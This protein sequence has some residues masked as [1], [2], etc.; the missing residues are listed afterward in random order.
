MPSQADDR[1][2]WFPGKNNRFGTALLTD[3]TN[4]YGPRGYLADG[5]SG[6]PNTFSGVLCWYDFTGLGLSEGS[7]VT[8]VSDSSSAGAAAMTNSGAVT[9]KTGV[10]NGLGGVNVDSARTLAATVT[11]ISGTTD[12]SVMIVAQKSVDSGTHAFW[13]DTTTDPNVQ[14]NTTLLTLDPGATAITISSAS[15]TST[16]FILAFRGTGSPG[17]HKLWLDTET[18]GV[19]G[20]SNAGTFA[21]ALTIGNGPV[22]TTNDLYVLEI[23]AWNK[24]LNSSEITAL[25]TYVENKYAI[26]IGA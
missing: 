22:A 20:S 6:N 24:E 2:L 25:A 14:W 11:G 10:Q 3:P 4:F 1:R 15:G 7:A 21:G 12:L 16:H 5:L 19:T 23:A 18:A 13:A 26:T 17:T 9:Y 8:S